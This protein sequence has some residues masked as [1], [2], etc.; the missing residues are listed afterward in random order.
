MR[1]ATSRYRLL[2]HLWALVFAIVGLLFAF[3]PHFTGAALARLGALLALGGSLDTSPEGLW[4]PLAVSLMVAVTGL[5]LLSASRPEARGPWLALLLAKLVSTAFFLRLARDGGAVW[6]IAAGADAFVALSLVLA[7]LALPRI[8]S[9]SYEVYFGKVDLAPR[10]AL[11]FRYTHLR[12]QQAG[13][14]F[15]EHASWAV[16]FDEGR[17]LA[18]RAFSSVDATL[19]PPEPG[20]LMEAG[21]GRLDATRASGEAGPIA[22]SLGYTHD[23]LFVSHVPALLRVLGLARSVYE[24]PVV[25]AR[26]DGWVQV[27]GARLDVRG[28]TG[29]IGHIQGRRSPLRWAW[30]HCNHFDQGEDAAFDGLSVRVLLGGR[31]SPTMSSFVLRLDGRLHRFSSILGVFR[32]RASWDRYRWSFEASEGDWRL[33]GEALAPP[34]EDEGGRRVALVEYTDTD[35]SRLWC[36]NSKLASLRLR[37]VNLQDGVE[38]LLV[39]TGAAAFEVVDR[40][41]PERTPDLGHERRPS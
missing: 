14:P 1:D 2:L 39:S 33:A 37:L 12:G 6:L 5:A 7:R 41:R 38:R 3:A 13:V 25:D 29:M 36:W 15:E 28:C 10:R 21:R 31:E 23:G 40:V 20:L 26:L 22:W 16:L 11:W 18:G 17:V 4:H 24:I 34:F 35:G 30:A 8:D 27:G 19:R 9:P 32:A